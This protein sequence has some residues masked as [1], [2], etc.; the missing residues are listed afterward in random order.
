[1]TDLAARRALQARLPRTWN[2][3]FA[4]H[5]NFTA[6]QV[7]AIPLLLAGHNVM[8]CAATAS[9]KTEAAVAPLLEQYCPVANR[10]AGL[11]IIYLTPTRALAS[12]LATRL[13]DPLRSLG[14]AFAVKTGD[15]QSLRPG[16]PPS[17]LLTTPESLDSLL[18]T[19]PRLFTEVKAIIIDELHLLHG[20][21]RGDQLQIV[22]NRVRRIREYA[23]T[24]GATGTATIQC[25]ALSAT[26]ADPA[27]VAHH[28]FDGAQLVTVPG[29]RQLR[30][31]NISLPAGEPAAFLSY[32]QT[33]RGKGIRKVLVFCN[34]RA[35]VE[36]YAAAV[37]PQSPFG[38]AVYVHYS[39]IEA[40]RRHEIEHQFAG[41]DAAICF[42]SNTL[43]LGIDIGTIDLV[44]LLGPP[45]SVASFVQRVGRGNR[46]HHYAAVA[47]F[48]R[49]P[50][51]RLIFEALVTAAQSPAPMSSLPAATPFRP[52]VAIQQI[53]SL[54]KQSPTG[55]V[56]LAELGQLFGT[57]LPIDDL[58][59]ILG[60][61]HLRNYLRI[62][63]P[64]EWRVGPR[65]NELLDQQAQAQ[66]GL[67]IHSNIQGNAGS[68]IEVRNQH[69]NQIVA[70]VDTPWFD[71]PTLTL[72]G[73]PVNVEWFD[74][75]V[76]WVAPSAGRDLPNQLPYRSTH[77]LLSY[78]LAQS[79]AAQVG[80]APGVAPILPAPDGWW[81]HWLGDVYGHVLLDLLRPH[82]AVAPT[83][84]LGLCLHPA[85]QSLSLPSW[86][87]EHVR[88]HLATH[89]HAIE[90]MLALGPF[91]HLLPDQLRRQSVIDQ[92]D[93]A[94]FQLALAAL[95]PTLAPDSL[96]VDL[97]ILLDSTLSS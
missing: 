11:R 7:A 93:I 89:Y 55:A 52:S 50:L 30:T 53:F 67:G 78:E 58:Q 83:E 81:F 38:D 1:M 73:R 80:L 96:T 88:Q 97:R 68:M 56:R 23:V 59:A 27:V 37:R 47:C 90:P 64:G 70:R 15:W 31:E 79:L 28:Y 94:R 76:L 49:S 33:L 85:D 2:A 62:G 5:G 60:Q 71:R 8:L 19:Q 41:D 32:L 25:A 92:F 21:P 12:D 9:G 54:L 35:E 13:A 17:V 77:Q 26:L 61:L 20:T 6:T 75:T 40:R 72:E 3:F 36:A 69:T 18:T 82:L 29:S 22:L 45:G 74:G 16:R 51:E 42:A 63:R 95:Q 24:D 66:P 4:R 34:T 44:I 84:Q 65:L 86:S 10:A 43:E 57:K 46:R 14:I 48:D 39:N 87:D 91:Q